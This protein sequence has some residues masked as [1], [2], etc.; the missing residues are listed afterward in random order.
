MFLISLFFTLK[1]FPFMLLGLH[2]FVFFC[3]FFLVVDFQS[4]LALW[5]EKMLGMISV[6]LKVTEVAF[7]AQDVINL[8]ECSMCT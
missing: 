3:R 7:V 2:V 4:L 1:K 5:L 8:R 6:F